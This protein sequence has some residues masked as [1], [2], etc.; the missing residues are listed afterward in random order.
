MTKQQIISETVDILEK[1]PI[2]KVEEIRNLI[3][4]YYRKKDEEVFEKGF[5][6]LVNDSKAY[7]FLN[8]EEDLYTVNDLIVRYK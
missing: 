6:K 4:D 1:I 2:E 8:N 7:D 3:I 5:R